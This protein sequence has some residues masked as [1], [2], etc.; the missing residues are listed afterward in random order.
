[1]VL[2]ALVRAEASGAVCDGPCISPTALHPHTHACTHAHTHVDTQCSH[3][4]IHTHKNTHTHELS[5][6]HAH[7]APMRA[8]ARRNIV[9]CVGS[10]A[11]LADLSV[12]QLEAALAGEAERVQVRM[13][14]MEVVWM[15]GRS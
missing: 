12:L 4:H 9:A 15:C 13:K 3:A 1:V 14:V 6:T 10:L 8:H 2:Q 7:I 5:H 11:E